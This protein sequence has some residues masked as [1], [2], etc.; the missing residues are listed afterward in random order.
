MNGEQVAVIEPRLERERP[1]LGG[2]RKLYRFDNG[3]GASVV[4]EIAV[5][6]PL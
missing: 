4:R 6:P 3:Y 1:Q 5:L 2:T